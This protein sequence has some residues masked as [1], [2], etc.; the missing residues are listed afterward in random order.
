VRHT[1]GVQTEVKKLLDNIGAT[2][3]K[4]DD[5]GKGRRGRRQN[6]P[7]AAAAAGGVQGGGGF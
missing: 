5:M 2:P 1:P 4:F 7:N 6:P 3:V